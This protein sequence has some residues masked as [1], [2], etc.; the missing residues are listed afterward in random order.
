MKGGLGNQMF[1]Y[2]LGLRLSE[3]YSEPLYFD[4]TDYRQQ[5]LRKFELG[6]FGIDN[7]E[8]NAATR[9][10]YNN[11]INLISRLGIK[12]KKVFY[13][14]S[15]AFDGNVFK[16]PHPVYFKGFFQSYKYF[17]GIEAEVRR[18][19]SFINAL[20]EGNRLIAAEI[21]AANSVSLHIRRGDYVFWD[22]HDSSHV[23][24][25]LDYYEKAMDLMKQKTRA[26]KFFV[27]T[28]DPDWIRSTFTFDYTLVEGNVATNSWKDMYLMSLCKHHIIANSTFS[29]WGAWLNPSAGKMVIVPKRWFG[30]EMNK[31]MEHLSP[32]EWIRM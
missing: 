5:D 24:C 23:L 29:W 15:L 13:E 28:D 8:I 1:Q 7:K 10:Y 3:K 4:L 21:R 22:K 20:D 11:L 18:R 17:S 14:K 31:E 12:H 16:I 32:P 6:V 2:A 30:N 25:D 27:F 9:F 26:C 19:F